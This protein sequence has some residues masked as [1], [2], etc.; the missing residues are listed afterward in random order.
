[1]SL[2]GRHRGR[3]LYE[4][5]M[6]HASHDLSPWQRSIINPS[7]VRGHSGVP[8]AMREVGMW[9]REGHGPAGQ[10]G[11]SHGPEVDEAGSESGD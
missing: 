10:D 6:S 7:V 9:Q 5:G 3:G 8:G 1:M 11:E 4:A 2:F